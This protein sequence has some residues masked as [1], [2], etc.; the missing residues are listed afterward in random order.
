MAESCCAL[1]RISNLERIMKL[2]SIF[3]VFASFSVRSSAAEPRALPTAH[4]T[5]DI[6]G[7]NIRVDDRL[8]HGAIH[9][10]SEK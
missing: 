1:K 2:S 9:Q 7:R 3:A 8:L 4:T 10:L 5:R 6:E